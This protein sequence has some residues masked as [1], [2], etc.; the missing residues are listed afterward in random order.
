MI[1]AALLLGVLSSDPFD[2]L[3]LAQGGPSARACGLLTAEDILAVQGVTL[4]EAKAADD[5]S[6]DLRFAQ[7]VFAATDVVRSVSLTVISG[8][9][10]AGKAYWTKTFHPQRSEAALKAALRKKDLPRHVPGLG[11]D[12]FWTGDAR[13]GALYVMRGDQILRISIGGVADEAERLQRSRVLAETA[14]RRLR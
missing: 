4:R 14:L 1:L 8:E 12:A 13:A 7:C 3:A 10:D 6:K 9:G 11:D 5:R 2:S